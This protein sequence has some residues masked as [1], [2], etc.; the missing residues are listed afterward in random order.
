MG[1][2][3]PVL[4]G[5]KR[6]K[7]TMILS[8]QRS[9]H[10]KMSAGHGLTR[11]WHPVNYAG[12]PIEATQQGHIPSGGHLAPAMRQCKWVVKSMQLRTWTTTSACSVVT[13]G[14]VHAGYETSIRRFS[15]PRH[16]G[17]CLAHR[18]A[19]AHGRRYPVVEV[20]PAAVIGRA[21][22]ALYRTAVGRGSPFRA[23]FLVVGDR[24]IW[25]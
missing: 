17:Q 11:G 4:T 25:P 3:Q 7:E 14:F 19:Y 6:P 10:G 2:F 8:R 16:S 12:P 9:I 13:A 24:R 22:M 18:T 1:R 23:R 5:R 20:N 21:C 15:R